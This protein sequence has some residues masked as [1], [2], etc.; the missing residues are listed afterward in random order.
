MLII[1][2][3]SSSDLI[4]RST[5]FRLQFNRDA[6]DCPVKPGNEENDEIVESAKRLNRFPIMMD[7]DRT[8]DRSEI[9]HL[10]G[11]SLNRLFQPVRTPH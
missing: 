9:N 8:R 1:Q 3:S 10:C 7:H 4:G 6:V 11:F 2:P 5:P